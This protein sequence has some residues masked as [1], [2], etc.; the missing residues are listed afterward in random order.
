MTT[1]SRIR[2]LG[3]RLMTPELIIFP[4][5]HHSPACSWQLR[6]LFA[7]VTPSSVLVEGPRSFTPLIP[8]LTHEAAKMPLAIYTYAVIKPKGAPEQRHASYFP[9]CDYSPELVALREAAKRS[10]PARFVDLDF[11]EQIYQEE[12]CDEKD[13]SSLLDEK[14]FRRS[15]HLEALAERLGCRDHEEL[16]EHLFEIDAGHVTLKEHV[17]RVAAYCELSRLDYSQ[18]DLHR[19][20]TL[21]REAEMVRHIREAVAGRAATDGPVVAIMGGFHAV[22]MPELLRDASPS[23]PCAT[24]DVVESTSALIR[25][26]FDRLERLNGYAAGMTSPAWQQRIWERFMLGDATSPPLKRTRQ[27]IALEMLSEVAA[28]LRSKYDVAIPM[29][30]LSAA[31]EQTLSLA[32]LRARPAVA[33]VD[34][35]DAITSCFIKGEVGTAGEAVLAIARQAFTGASIGT[36]PPGAGTPPLVKD[37]MWRLRKQ[38]LKIDN[39]ERQKTTLDIYRNPAHRMTSRLLHGLTF[40]GIP[41]AQRIAGPDFIHGQGLNRLQEKWDYCH[42]AATEGALVEASVHGA[43]L[44]LAVAHLFEKKLDAF[45]AGGALATARAGAALL[46]QAFV[47][48]LHDHLPAALATLRTSIGHDA[49]F[50]SVTAAAAAVSLLAQAREPLEA[51]DAGELGV[52][53]NTA[54]ERATFLGEDLSVPADDPAKVVRALMRWREIL[55]SAA[56]AQL[57]ASLYWA[58]LERIQSTHPVPIMQG[59]ATGLRYS[60]GYLGADAL[61]SGIV[62]HLRGH[63][64]PQDAAAFMRGLLQTAREVAWQQPELL[65][66]LDELLAQWDDDAFTAVLPELRLAFAEMTPRETDRIARVVAQRHGEDQLG[67]LVIREHSAAD[68]QYHLELSKVLNGILH[69]DHLAEWG[70]A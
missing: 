18:E 63:A 37:V 7:T 61:Q 33:R 62:G 35:L 44:P 51:L 15:A 10:I 39:I 56:G 60:A 47:L 24:G 29:P 64:K 67:T 26:S 55:V 4:V 65:D 45:R 13:G 54:Y 41:F 2:E 6:R 49:E 57:D 31:Y 46:T 36:V 12:H 38:K 17:S 25:Y 66:A 59:A 23:Q 27:D 16:W 20:G 53:L 11:A 58:M 1:A 5:R 30:A 32:R 21:V 34:V 3:D 68:V 8:L 70:G 19:D 40:L 50:E 14:R 52:L 48:G 28:T 22:A 69:E 43:T 42:T 9:M